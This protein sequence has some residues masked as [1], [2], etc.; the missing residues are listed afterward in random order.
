MPTKSRFGNLYLLFQRPV[1]TLPNYMPNT[2]LI[3]QESSTGK[4]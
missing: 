2:I 1:A 4:L 3:D